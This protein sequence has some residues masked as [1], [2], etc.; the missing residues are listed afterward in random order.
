MKVIASCAL[1]A[2]LLAGGSARADDAKGTL[3]DA[4]ESQAS[5]PSTPPSLPD[6]A[7]ARARTVQETVAHGLKG[8]EERKAHAAPGD[9]AA[10]DARSE[11]TA[12]ATEGAAASAAKSA[13]SAAAAAAG[14]ARAAEARGGRVPGKPPSHPGG[15][16]PGHPH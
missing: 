2:A 10:D 5:A 7:A 6:E 4:L 3:H 1:A 9:T 16:P 13:N 8:A 11:A 14:Q 15:P 12:H